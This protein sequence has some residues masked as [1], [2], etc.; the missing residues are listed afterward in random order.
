MYTVNHSNLIISITR[1]YG[2]GGREIGQKLAAAWGVSYYDKELLKRL[3]EETGLS[4]DVIEA[5]D[6]KPFSHLLLNPYRFLSGTDG[7]YLRSKVHNAEM[8][9]IRQLAEEESCVFVGRGVESVLEDFPGLVRLFVCAPLEFRIQR[10]MER[11]SL[12]AEEAEKRIAQVDKERAAYYRYFT[13][14]KWGFASNYDL[15]INSGKLGIDGAVD[16]AA[17]FIEQL[18]D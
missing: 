17:R 5:F 7:D 1:E 3:A 4:N 11:N 10:V 14:Q 16:L 8:S 12:T 18:L 6:E 15:C 13:D 2:S 9:L